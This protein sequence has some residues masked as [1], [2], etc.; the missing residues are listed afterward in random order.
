MRKCL[1]LCTDTS[2]RPLTRQADLDSQLHITDHLQVPSFLHKL[3]R[4]TDPWSQHA[5]T[6][7]FP[8]VL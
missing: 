4:Q 7:V 2:L 8:K 6:L 1:H 5:H 3:R